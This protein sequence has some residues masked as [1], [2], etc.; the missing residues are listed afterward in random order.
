MEQR[1]DLLQGISS[2]KA[3]ARILNN[4]IV[5]SIFLTW[6]ATTLLDRNQI[7]L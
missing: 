1:M 7:I 5:S 3:V 6:A 4:V 2:E